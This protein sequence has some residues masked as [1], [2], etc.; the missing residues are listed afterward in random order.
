MDRRAV[1]TTALEV[2]DQVREKNITFMAGS[3]AHSALVSLLPILLLAL[4]ITSAVGSETLNE[5][6]AA[7]S[8]N[9]LSPAGEGL[10]FSALTNASERAGASLLGVVSLLWGMLRVFRGLN[11]AF[12]ELYG[13]RET[14][15]VT[16]LIHGFVII[17]A[18]VVA[19]LGTALAGVLFAFSDQPIRQI[20]NP[21]V[22]VVGLLIGFYP[23]YYLLPEPE[24]DPVEALPGTVIAAV[25][26]VALEMLFGVYVELA[27]TATAFGLLG[28]VILLLIWLY[29]I[30]FILLTGTTVNVV[31]A[32]RHRDGPEGE[33]AVEPENWKETL[34]K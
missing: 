6:I 20:L 34:L 22:L 4:V 12:D 26:W 29:G 23:I 14:G 31:L 27:N 10:I 9:H 24:I 8:R 19:V 2:V 5:Q 16:Q 13:S 32:G 21:I 1:K 7:L 17:F 11:T 25:G 33:P 3:I 28:S 30:A 18:I 15:L